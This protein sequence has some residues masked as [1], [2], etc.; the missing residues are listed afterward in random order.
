MR[1]ATYVWMLV[2]AASAA[3][4]VAGCTRDPTNVTSGLA[5]GAKLAF[6]GQPTFVTVGTAIAPAVT[7]EVQDSLGVLMAADTSEITLALAPA[8][9]GAVLSG[10]TTRRA[11]GGIATF[12]DLSVSVA[13]S[14]YRL[15]ASATGGASVNSV[16]FSAIPPIKMISSIYEACALTAAGAAYCTSDVFSN[17]VPADSDVIPSLVAGFTFSSVVASGGTDCGVTSGG[18]AYCW[19]TGA[20]YVFGNG[21]TLDSPTPV[22]VSG[23]LAFSSVSSWGYMTCGLTTAGAAYCWGT[24]PLGNG[25]TMGPGKVPTA[26][27]GGLTFKSLSAG[28]NFVCGVTTTNAAYCWGD[29]RSGELGGTVTAAND[30]GLLPVAVSGGLAF[31]S[32]S[33]GWAQACGVTT[34]GKAYCWGD[35][36]FGQVGTAA[37]DS[38]C[39]GGVSC[40]NVP[41]AVALDSTFTAVGTGEDV[42]C[43]LTTGG[44]VY[45]W[46]NLKAAPWRVAGLPALVSLTVG[47]LDACGVTATGVGYCWDAPSSN[48]V[49]ARV[50]LF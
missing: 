50:R 11:S 26:V 29:T 22:A 30:Y 17:R 8:R 14:N 12:A 3:A 41:V 40:S 38:V 13:D 1:L 27:N 39:Q 43:G 24:G 21:D 28:Y 42:S 20:G 10:T 44:S 9:N 23:G 47:G 32:V 35:N 2:G 4:A 33:A 15:V 36:Q 6:V 48:P 49:V 5:P 31:A 37:T 19:G 25:T 16:R 46:G 7:V 34:A 45:C 18:A